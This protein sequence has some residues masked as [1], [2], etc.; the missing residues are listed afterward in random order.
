MLI[1][2]CGL[3]SLLL[4]STGREKINLGKEL[5]VSNFY[6]CNGLAKLKISHL[7]YI[8]NNYIFIL[9]IIIYLVS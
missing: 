5:E 3:A 9:L 2:E 1:I 8:Y 7:K 4:I 6:A